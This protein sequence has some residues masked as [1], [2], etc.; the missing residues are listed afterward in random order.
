MKAI[1]GWSVIRDPFTLDLDIARSN[2]IPRDARLTKNISAPIRFLADHAPQGDIMRQVVRFLLAGLLAASALPAGAELKTR[3]APSAPWPQAE[4]D[5]APDPAVTFG[6]LANGMRYAIMPNHMPKG[7]VSLR[8]R[9]DAG[10]LQES[11]SQRGLAHFLEHMAF[12]GSAHVRDNEA[13]RIL[14]RFGAAMGADSNAYTQQSQTVYKI[15]LPKNDAAG[16]DSA[17]MLMRE[18]AGDLTLSEAA[19]ESERSVVLSEE[20]A[21]D[22]P[23]ARVQKAQLAFD[24]PGQPLGSRPPIGAVEVLKTAK[25][26]DIR[27]FYDAYYRPE[28]ATLIVVG[29]VSPSSIEKKIKLRFSHWRGR[30]P[31]GTDPVLGPPQER[32]REIAEHVEAGAQTSVSL[33]W[34]KPADPRPDTR[35]HERDELVEALGMM[36]FNQRLDDMR[37]SS[38]PPFLRAGG[39]VQQPGR[40][41][42]VGSLGVVTTE[43]GWRTGLE[44]VARAQRLL[45]DKGVTQA[46]I[47]RQR[48]NWRSRLETAAAS[49]ATRRT[50]SL[51]DHLVGSVDQRSVFVT[52]AFDL[53]LFDEIAPQVTVEQVDAALRDS[54]SGNGPLIFLGGPQPMEG[55]E[56]VLADAAIAAA[57][58]RKSEAPRPASWPYTDFGTPGEVVERHEVP[59]LGVT[60]LRFANGV[61]LTV[62][63]TAFHADQILVAVDIGH[64]RLDYAPDAAPPLWTIGSNAF[65]LGGYRDLTVPEIKRL[66]TG[67]QAGVGVALWDGSVRFSGATRPQDLSL[68][69]QMITAYLTAPGWR[70]EGL[71]LVRNNMIDGFPQ[72]QANPAWVYA[73]AGAQLLHDGDPRWHSPDLAEVQAVR[74]D[75]MRQLIEPILSREPI[76]VAIVG[77]VTV[78]QAV[79]ETAATLG[80]LPPRDADTPPPA[81]NRRVAFPEPGSGPVELHHKGR[82][83]QGLAIAAWPGPDGVSDIHAPRAARLLQLILQ[84]RL[85]DEFRTRLGDSYSPGSDM[86]SSLEFPG[87]GFIMAYAETPQTKMAA[88][89][90]TLASIVR[91]LREKDVST[92]E[93]ERARKPRI[94]TLLKSRQTNEYWLGTLQRAQSEPIWLE[95]IRTTIPDL[96]GMTPA[97][98]RKLAA[99]YLRDDRLW[100]LR[101]TPEGD[102][103]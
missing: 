32:G 29:D 63:P 61:R 58:P 38:D 82:S 94:E 44:Q 51:A 79:A 66:L 7:Q 81:G 88:F 18:T 41:A 92:D 85:T 50:A 103:G 62:K 27:A 3:L 20:R 33:M 30:G 4:S 78:E 91:D 70:S 23:G 101:V 22:T 47:D 64:G 84:Q 8:F 14:E 13:F 72:W 40:S 37:L 25:A 89:D 39:G 99:T 42:L 6:T 26:A 90:E 83:D 19:V 56:Q 57:E 48:A 49:A 28:R 95:L 16:I 2:V 60:M 68:Q 93:F 75:Q 80:A 87:Y 11:E 71:E 10:S 35:A 12:R 1:L 100:R 98:I 9:I 77:D 43:Q 31:A 65:L 46:E 59:D 102:K 55:A 52:P 5:L 96:Q 53:A 45:L 69:M 24:F 76:E 54:F 34:T 36:A 86:E 74:Y 21:G 67:R 17:L 97:D 15:D 73:R